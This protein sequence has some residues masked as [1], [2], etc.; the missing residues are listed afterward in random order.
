MA[1]DFRRS[2]FADVTK[3]AGTGDHR[4]GNR[5]CVPDIAR[6]FQRLVRDISTRDLGGLQMKFVAVDLTNSLGSPKIA[7]TL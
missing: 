5:L 7:D 1:A 6:I 4:L 3:N 2:M